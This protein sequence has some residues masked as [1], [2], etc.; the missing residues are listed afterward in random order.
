MRT[1]FTQKQALV[2]LYVVLCIG[3]ELVN[4]V[5][6]KEEK[7]DDCHAKISLLQADNEQLRSTLRKKRKNGK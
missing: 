6:E 3:A 5:I 4:Q 2:S 1:S 7:L